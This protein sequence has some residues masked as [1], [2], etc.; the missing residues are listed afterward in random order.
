MIFL[1][2]VA[3]LL[4]PE[5]LPFSIEGDGAWYLVAGG[6]IEK[7]K[8]EEVR[9]SNAAPSKKH[10]EWKTRRCSLRL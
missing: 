9:Q 1:Q 6:V 3:F 4:T 8:F 2:L 10:N 5:H 7:A